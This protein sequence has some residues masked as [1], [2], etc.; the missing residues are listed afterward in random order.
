MF[1]DPEEEEEFSDSQVAHIQALQ[2]IAPQFL[3]R[4]HLWEKSKR[5]PHLRN[6]AE[7]EGPRL[8]L[9]ESCLQDINR[10]LMKKSDANK[11]HGQD[12]KR[13]WAV[14]T[15][16]YLD[17]A[18]VNCEKNRMTLAREAAKAEGGNEHVAR[19]I[20]RDEKDWV[21]YR[22]VPHGQWGR[23]FKIW[24][25][26]DDPGTLAF[27]HEKRATLGENFN[28]HRLIEYL[29]EY[30]HTRRRE[31]H[32]EATIDHATDLMHR[33]FNNKAFDRNDVST[34]FC[35]TVG[36]VVRWLHRLG[37]SYGDVRKGVYKDGHEREDVVEDR[38][39]RF[40]PLLLK[41][42]WP[43]IREWKLIQKKIDGQ[44]CDFFEEI[45]K[46]FPPN[47]PKR[48]LLAYDQ[49]T[50]NS[51]DGP[52]QQWTFKDNAPMHPK[53]RGPG[54]MT[55]DMTTPLGRLREPRL[56]PAGCPLLPEHLSQQ[57]EVPDTFVEPPL[58][59]TSSG[60]SHPQ[61]DYAAEYLEYGKGTW[62][63]CE[64]V[65][66]HFRDVALPMFERAFPGCQAICLLDNA[67]S[68]RAM[69][70][71][72]LIASRMQLSPGGDVKPMR[73]SWYIKLALI[74]D[75]WQAPQPPAPNSFIMQV[76]PQKYHCRKVKQKMQQADGVTARGLREI[77]K[78]RGLWPDEGFKRQCDP[79]YRASE[80]Q[81]CV[82]Q[83]KFCC[84]AATMA[85]QPDFLEQ[86]SALEEAIINRGH[87]PL[88]LPKFH[89]EFNWIEPCW[90]REKDYTR[91]H[92]G[93]NISSL[94]AMIPQAMGPK[95][96]PP[97]LVWKYYNK[98]LRIM[99]CYYE[100]NKFG[101]AAFRKAYTS[102]RRTGRTILK[103]KDGGGRTIVPTG[104]QTM[105]SRDR[106]TA[107]PTEPQT[108]S[109]TD[110]ATIVLP[111]GFQTM[112]SPTDRI[113]AV[114]TGPQTMSSTDRVTIVPPGGSQTM[115]SS[116][117]TSPSAP[118]DVQH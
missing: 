59:Q 110:Y 65:V 55:S 1:E 9:I 50:F 28:A 48:V 42:L 63:T 32:A 12:L 19:R 37:M 67:P 23:H 91:H 44:V 24:T 86:K 72:A 102:H 62:W 66:A 118:S 75:T 99:V 56:T 38:Q 29:R 95:N 68:H 54:I 103:S 81:K 87:I 51:H 107:M 31:F 15:L 5:W 39:Q 104:P 80:L 57:P 97:L 17:K 52:H 77:L 100:G 105:S 71:D 14:K 46:E 49:T 21:M 7:R 79:Q 96:L 92:C 73:E 106:I 109:S 22:F 2:A 61:E 27:I 4:K 83:G 35:V 40:L 20:L 117:N 58:P 8:E 69:A 6:K 41:E 53:E 116:D 3:R 18:D 64:N 88:F 98:C 70:A 89:P 30:W 11:P 36:T 76:G 111:G 74:D 82:A 108:M 85:L 78:E 45:P 60:F 93:Y 16:H 101:T 25:M 43:T 112:I 10:L 34:D 115:S 84:A 47:T 113:T 33:L 114:P 90:A 13:L 94:R 26:L